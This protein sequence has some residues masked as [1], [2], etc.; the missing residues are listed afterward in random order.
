VDIRAQNGFGVVKEFPQW[1][2]KREAQPPRTNPILS[3]KFGNNT[4]LLGLVVWCQLYASR[5]FIFQVKVNSKDYLSYGLII[6]NKTTERMRDPT[7]KITIFATFCEGSFRHTI[8][9][10]T[11]GDRI[12]RT[13]RINIPH[14]DG[15]PHM[16]NKDSLLCSGSMKAIIMIMAC[17]KRY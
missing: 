1:V 16:P 9:P 4:W 12:G 15:N 10:N 11:M 8:H 14:K 5:F 7:K 3:C 6:L 2:V 17:S 13:N